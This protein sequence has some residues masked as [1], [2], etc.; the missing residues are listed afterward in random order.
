[1]LGFRLI[2]IIVGLSVSAYLAAQECNSNK[3]LHGTP[4]SRFLISQEGDYVTDTRTGLQ[5]KRCAE[6]QTW[7]HDVQGSAGQCTGKAKNYGFREVKSK[8]IAKHVDNHTWH[9]PNIKE[10]ASIVETGC[11]DP[12]INLTV[13]PSTPSAGFWTRS[14]YAHEESTHLWQVYFK[15]GAS[16]QDNG[17]TKHIRL[18]R[19]A[20]Q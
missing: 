8:F 10:L 13:F 14:T 16:L 12:A 17:F 2:V 3:S 9:L 11:F 4:T 6:G 5:W 15:R 1:M 19:V 20:P 7:R 18:V